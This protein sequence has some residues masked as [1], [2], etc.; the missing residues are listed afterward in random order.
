[1]SPLRALAPG[2][3]APDASF[4]VPH[5]AMADGKRD[6][7]RGHASLADSRNTRA[8]WLRWSALSH[9]WVRVFEHALRRI[10]DAKLI[11][12]GGERAKRMKHALIVYA[13]EGG[14]TFF[15][16]DMEKVEAMEQRLQGAATLTNSKANQ[17]SF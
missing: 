10:R 9:F 6:R 3:H 2:A 16:T 11:E 15:A 17:K 8:D 1:M 13:R 4:A 7:T 5:H 14:Y 12:I